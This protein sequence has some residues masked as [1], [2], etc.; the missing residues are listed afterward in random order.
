M[1]AYQ[2][3]ALRVLVGF[4]PYFQRLLDLG[5]NLFPRLKHTRFLRRT[6]IYDAERKLY[7]VVFRS[8]FTFS[9]VHVEKRV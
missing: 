6:V 2:D 7:I 9:L 1:E 8:H 3:M 5:E 4:H